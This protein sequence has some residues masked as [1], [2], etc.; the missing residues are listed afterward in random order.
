MWL[1]MQNDFCVDF[2]RVTF[3]S[4]RLPEIKVLMTI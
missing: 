3:A 1:E 4:H 2:M